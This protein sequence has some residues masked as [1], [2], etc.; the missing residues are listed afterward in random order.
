L[1]TLIAAFKD[2]ATPF[3]KKHWFPISLGVAAVVFLVWGMSSISYYKNLLT[4]SRIAAKIKD[5][6]ISTQ[7]LEYSQLKN[8]LTIVKEKAKDNA[9]AEKIKQLQA[10]GKGLEK[11][12]KDIVEEKK[13]LIKKLDG[14]PIDQLDKTI[15][16]AIK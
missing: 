2:V 4:K 14:Q 1:D 15:E 7:K 13:K 12:R 11:K 5:S 16:D 3:L 10:K 9:S 6:T 8:E